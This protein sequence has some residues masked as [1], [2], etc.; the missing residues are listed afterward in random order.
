MKFPI[1]P[2]IFQAQKIMVEDVR[3]SLAG[4]TKCDRCGGCCGPTMVT[5]PEAAEILQYLSDN[6]LWKKVHEALKAKHDEWDLDKRLKCPLVDRDE[7]GKSV[8]LVY[9]VRPVI[10]RAFGQTKDKWMTCPH[11]GTTGEGS[12]G[13]LEMYNEVVKSSPFLLA[14]ILIMFI[15]ENGRGDE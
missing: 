3:N 14:E 4:T 5:A 10:C 8:C 6:K 1:P 7:N 11:H 12:R 13:M 9:D 2:R 15:K